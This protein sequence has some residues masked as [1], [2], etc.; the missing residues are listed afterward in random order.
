V[1]SPCPIGYGRPNKLGS[2]L[3]EMKYYREN[4]L[5]QNN[6]DPRDADIGLQGKII[7]GK[8]IDQSRPTF[9]ELY[10]ENILKKFTRSS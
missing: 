6:A 10:A 2:G 4:S 8:F 9:D 1:I 3:N 5:V 7:V